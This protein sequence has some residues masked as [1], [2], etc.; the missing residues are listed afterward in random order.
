MRI[1]IALGGNA[2]L[3][4]GDKPDAGVSHQRHQPASGRRRARR[5]ARPSS[6]R[7]ATTSKCVAF[8]TDTDPVFHDH[9]SCP[10]GVEIKTHHNDHPGTGHRRQCDWCAQ[11]EQPVAATR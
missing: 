2:L 3:E 6:A 5:S 10:Y 8:Y 1:V 7:T 11:H 4:R 9:D